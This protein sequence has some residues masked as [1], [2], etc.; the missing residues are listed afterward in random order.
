MLA[1]PTLILSENKEAISGGSSTTAT[2]LSNATLV[3]LMPMNFITVGNKVITN[4][5]VTQ[6]ESGG[7]P[8]CEAEFGTE[9]IT[10]GA[11]VHKI[12]DNGYVTFSLSPELAS[13]TDT[14]NIPNCGIIKTLSVRRLD[15]GG[16]RV[17]DGQTL[18]LSGVL[19]KSDTKKETKIP[20]FGSI[21]IIGN[22]FKQK[23]DFR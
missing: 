18:I 5:S 4:Y 6:S 7:A 12:D 20:I 3:D 17:K 8:T 10:F 23:F 19:S 16:V 11:K 14:V 21:P 9:G 2:N 13:V 1:N 22:L 15:T